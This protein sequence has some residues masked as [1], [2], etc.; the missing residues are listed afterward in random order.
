[1][2]DIEFRQ[3]FWREKNT[4]FFAYL[5]SQDLRVSTKCFKPGAVTEAFKSFT[6]STVWDKQY[7]TI[8]IIGDSLGILQFMSWD[9]LDS[10]SLYKVAASKAPTAV[11]ANI[12]TSPVCW[13][14]W[15]GEPILVSQQYGQ[16]IGKLQ[17]YTKSKSVP[18]LTPLFA[19]SFSTCMPLYFFFLK[20]L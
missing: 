8:L 6:A 20:H 12:M 14:V 4:N 17:I 11:C 2:S 7:I 10:E 19:W 16:Q 3:C 5:L 13:L 1:M 9:D 15:W 18:C